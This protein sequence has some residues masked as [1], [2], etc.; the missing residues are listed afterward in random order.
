MDYNNKY[1]RMCKKEKSKEHFYR[2]I[3]RKTYGICCDDEGYEYC[4]KDTVLCSDCR[5]ITYNRVKKHK[6]KIIT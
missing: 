2:I 1:C 6:A 3:K 4:Y 5:E